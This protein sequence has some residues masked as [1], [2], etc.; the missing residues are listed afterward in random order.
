MALH[1]CIH[2]HKSESVNQSDCYE[3]HFQTAQSMLFNDRLDS[4]KYYFDKAIACDPLNCI[5]ANNIAI[6][7]YN[8]SKYEIAELYFQKLNTECRNNADF[9]LNHALNL[10][11]LDS[12][13]EVLRELN[14]CIAISPTNCKCLYLRSVYAD[15]PDTS[16]IKRMQDLECETQIQEMKGQ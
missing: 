1:A 8:H 2:H 6:E 14:R 3:Y 13:E 16:L 11:F 10:T 9:I 15:S 5:Y 7:Y 4:A 12:T